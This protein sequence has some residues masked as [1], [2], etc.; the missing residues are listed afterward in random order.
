MIQIPLY[1]SLTAKLDGLKHTE[2]LSQCSLAGQ[3]P[4]WDVSGVRP[5]GA[6]LKTFGGR[7]S[8]PEPLVDL[9]QFT[10]EV[11]RASAGR[12]LSSIE[13]HDLC[14]KI[15]QSSSSEESDE[16]ALISLSNLTDD[17]IRRASQD[18]GG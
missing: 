10:V 1:T 8:G 9:F 12:R 15:A 16:A 3:V 14:C 7:A 13:C 11:F 2:N 5:A 4:K 6:A 18:S 17:R